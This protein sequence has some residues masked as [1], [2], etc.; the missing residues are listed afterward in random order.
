MIF[1]K[2]EFEGVILLPD[3]RSVDFFVFIEKRNVFFLCSILIFSTMYDI[4]IAIENR[5]LMCAEH[6]F[7]DII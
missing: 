4:L 3:Y 5:I 1:S 7:P 2:I 6:R